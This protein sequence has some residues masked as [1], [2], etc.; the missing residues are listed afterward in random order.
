MT[1]FALIH[2]PLCGPATWQPVATRLRA[3]GHQVIVPRLMD[4]ERL[5]TPLWQQ[6]AESIAAALRDVPAQQPIMWVAHSGA[7]LRLPAYRASVMNL[8]AAYV[9][10]DAGIP[11]NFPA[12][13]MSQLDCMARDDAAFAAMLRDELT[14]GRRFPAW[15]DDDLHDA[16]PDDTQRA[17]MLAELQPRGLRYF[18]ERLPAFAGWPDAPCAYLHFSAGYDADAAFA[19]S[20]QWPYRRIDAG[21]FHMLVDPV[22]TAQAIL[23]M[24]EAPT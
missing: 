16:I 22:A 1:T 18:E 3:Q 7:G 19:R 6:Q 17:Q 9:F 4:D 12:Q 13:G 2:S 15:T 20:Q 14:Q 23:D 8:A 21:H 11:H 24:V 10:V 5:R